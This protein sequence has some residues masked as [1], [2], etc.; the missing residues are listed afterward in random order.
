ML[1][2]HT[3]LPPL[4]GPRAGKPGYAGR[5]LGV[6][7]SIKHLPD[8][9]GSSGHFSQAREGFLLI[10]VSSLPDAY[11]ALPDFT[12]DIGAYIQSTSRTSEETGL[13]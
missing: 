2:M 6:S 13:R 9:L 11:Q 3:R 12:L 1:H 7:T 10:D 4:S 8:T 5:Q